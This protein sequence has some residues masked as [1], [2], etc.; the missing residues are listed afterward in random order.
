MTV[1]ASAAVGLDF[2][3]RTFCKFRR[4]TTGDGGRSAMRIAPRPRNRRVRRP[5]SPPRKVRVTEETLRPSQIYARRHRNPPRARKPTENRRKAG[6]R[7]ERHPA[8]DAGIGRQRQRPNDC[9]RRAARQRQGRCRRPCPRRPTRSCRRRRTSRPTQRRRL[10]ARSL[11]PTSST[12]STG[13]CTEQPA[14]THADGCDG[15]GQTG[16]GGPRPGREKRQFHPGQDLADRKD[17]H[18]LRRPADDG[19]GRA[20]VHGVATGA[21][22]RGIAASGIRFPPHLKPTPAAGTLPANRQS[23]VDHGDVR[24]HHCRE[25]GRGRHHHAEPAENA[26]RAVVRRVSRDRGGRRRPRGRRQDRLHPA[27]RQRKG[28]R[29]RRRHQ[30]DAAEKLHRHVLQRFRRDRRRPR[31]HLP[32]T[33]DRGR[34][35]LCARRRLRAR[36]DVR[37]HHRRPT[38]QNSASRK[39]RSAPSRASAAPSG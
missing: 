4:T 1:K 7:Y 21:S 35:R 3:G 30:G 6:R 18:R 5:A 36:H 12:M 10:D 27:H 28:V 31:R 33:D 24:I 26:Q 2:R 29:R 22:G 23:G 19:V 15:L 8:R 13:R 20:H 37:H 9:G 34:Q 17:L 32:Q 14:A 16:R 38:P 11:P 39:S 25:Q